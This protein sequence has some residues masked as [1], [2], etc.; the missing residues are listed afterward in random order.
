MALAGAV[1]ALGDPLFSK[2][3]DG[4]VL[5]IVIGKTGSLLTP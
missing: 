3:V 4:G 2:G 1:L 5:L